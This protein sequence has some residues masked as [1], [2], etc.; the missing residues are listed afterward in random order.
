METISCKEAR[1]NMAEVVNK[2]VYG[3][4]KWAITRR[5]KEVAVL[6]SYEEWQAI[7]KLL[8]KLED[9]EDLLDAK[10]AKKRIQSHGGIS[11]AKVKKDLGL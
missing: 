5:G 2:V 8:E 7:E 10:S 11:L 6:I 3:H 1:D 4:E 9:E